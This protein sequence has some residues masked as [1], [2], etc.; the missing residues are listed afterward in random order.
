[1]NLLWYV[2]NYVFFFPFLSSFVSHHNSTWYLPCAWNCIKFHSSP[3]PFVR[4]C[5]FI[6]EGHGGARKVSNDNNCLLPRCYGIHSYV[7]RHEWR[8]LQQRPWLVS[9][10]FIFFTICYEIPLKEGMGFYFKVWKCLFLGCHDIL[11]LILF[12]ICFGIVHTTAKRYILLRKTRKKR[13][14]ILYL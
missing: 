4:V 2:T 10:H 7:W 5:V 11:L 1:M 12:V 13:F 6:C 9:Q 14:S 8:I 3:P